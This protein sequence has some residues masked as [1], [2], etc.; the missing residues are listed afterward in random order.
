M[1]KPILIL[2]AGGSAKV[3]LEAAQRSGRQVLGLTDINPQMTGTTVLG[4]KVLGSDAVLQS[5][6]PE[7]VE[8]VNGLGSVRDNSTRQKLFETCLANGY[9]FASIMH[10][11]AILSKFA[12]FGPGFQAMAGVIVQPG[13]HVGRNVLLNTGVSIDHDCQIQD[14]A[15]IAPGA[16]LSGGVTVGQ[17]A[18]IGIGARIIQGVRIGNQAVIG[19]GSVVLHD[20]PDCAV[21]V[22]HHKILTQ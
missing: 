16:V 3:V 17:A 22:G 8:L 9:L 11:S 6:A 5:Y 13:C 10:P 12:A 21:V 1:T 15:H 19:A 2:G 14:H 20:V 7:T 18:F 4:C